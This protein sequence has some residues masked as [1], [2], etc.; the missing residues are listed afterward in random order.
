MEEEL[1]CPQ[2]R[3]FLRQPVLLPCGHSYCRDC[4]L[5]LKQQRRNEGLLLPSLPPLPQ[6][7][8]CSSSIVP[9]FSSSS[10]APS[11]SCWEA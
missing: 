8:L 11:S 10:S 1:K 7:N 2:C 6:P 4:V 9:S 5:L 3:H